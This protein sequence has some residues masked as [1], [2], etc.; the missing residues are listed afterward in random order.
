M[1]RGRE[2]RL[3]VCEREYMN[4]REE[5]EEAGGRGRERERLLYRRRGY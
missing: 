3:C 5:G 1:G 4:E 2:K